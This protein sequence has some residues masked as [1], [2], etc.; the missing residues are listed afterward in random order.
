MTD[1][2]YA[3]LFNQGYFL[4]EHDPSFLRKLIRATEESAAEANEP[5]GAGKSQHL[6][7]KIQE[8]L[9][10]LDKSP[11]VRSKEIGLDRDL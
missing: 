5:L 2:R 8:K 9:K 4:S 11:S 1:D 3:K 10:S 6:Q 7:E